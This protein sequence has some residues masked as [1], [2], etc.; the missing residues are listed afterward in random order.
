MDKTRMLLSQLNPGDNFEI[1]GL[2]KNYRNLHLIHLSFGS[3]IISG[4]RLGD[5]TK[6]WGDFNNQRVSD[7]CEVRKLAGKTTIKKRKK[8]RQRG[9]HKNKAAATEAA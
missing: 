2:E 4:E 3:A 5:E 8:C 6:E 1:C 9:S 7:G